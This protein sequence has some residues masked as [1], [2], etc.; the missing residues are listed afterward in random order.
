MEKPS[1]LSLI[2][3]G[4]VGD[5]SRVRVAAYTD[6]DGFFVAPSEL[7]YGYKLYGPGYNLLAAPD[8]TCVVS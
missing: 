1:N 6:G 5:A 2:Y 8:T 3:R 7:Q 4:A